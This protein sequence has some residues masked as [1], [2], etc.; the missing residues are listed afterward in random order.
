MAGTL[1]MAGP[2]L[3]TAGAVSS[4]VGAYYKAKVDRAQLR[5]QSSIAKLNAGYAEQQAQMASRRGTRRQQASRLNTA[6]MRGRQVAGF[7]ANGIDLASDTA[8]RIL[9]TTDLMGEVDALTIEQDTVDQV[10]NARRQ[11]TD[12]RNQSNMASA[13]AN[14]ISPNSA[15]F[16]SLLGDAGSVASSWYSWKKVN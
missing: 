6:A 10:W 13:S 16:G 12:F 4:A 1:G 11:A 2:M 5:Y 9:A 7:A 14:G 15:L 3:Q 8:G